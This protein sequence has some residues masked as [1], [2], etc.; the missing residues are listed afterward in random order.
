MEWQRYISASKNDTVDANLLTILELGGA[1]V[2]VFKLTLLSTVVIPALV[3]PGIAVG[4]TVLPTNV[5]NAV[6]GKPTLLPMAKPRTGS[7]QLAA[8]NPCKVGDA[9]KTKG[10]SS[11]LNP[12]A[13]KIKMRAMVNPQSAQIASILPLAD[14]H[15]HPD[16]T[17]SPSQVREQMN[18]NGVQ[19]AGSGVVTWP[20]NLEGRRDVWENYSRELGDRFIPFAGQSELNRVFQL[21]GSKAMADAEHPLVKTFLK[22][23]EADIEA[24]RVKGVGTYFINNLDTDDRPAFRRKVPGNASAIKAIYALVARYGSVLRVHLQQ[25]QKTISQFE[26]VMSSDRRG[27]VLWNQCGSTTSADQ[28]RALLER[29]SNLYC[30]FSWRFPPVT[31]PEFADRYIFDQRGPMPEWLQL[32]EDYPDRFMFG[33]DG[34]PGEPYDCA[35]I[36]VRRNLL[37]FLR[38]ATARKIAFEN[39][40][41][42]FGLK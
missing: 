23:L 19:W 39:T 1:P 11:C 27:R 18:H 30:E 12:P 29:H 14:M 28:V 22:E 13:R 2:K 31:R 4:D 42:V 21:G 41:R 7:I 3:S 35:T 10:A 33:N 16:Y 15:L 37:P 9:A 20:K 6:V 17:I 32:M 5:V 25:D 8:C 26:T 24:G 38:P 36:A 34:H 40:M